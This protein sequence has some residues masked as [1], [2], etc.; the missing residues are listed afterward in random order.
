MRN[1]L[2]SI[3]CFSC[4]SAWSNDTAFLKVHFLYGSKPSKAYQDTE[5]KWFGGVLGGHV[6]IEGGQHK[7]LNFLPQ[8]SFHVFKKENNRHSTYA[9]HDTISFYGILGGEPNS[10]KKAVVYIPITLQQKQRFDS[11]AAAYLAETP[12]DYALVGMRCGSAAY[13]ILARL[14][15]LEQYGRKKTAKKIFYP[16][17]LRKRLLRKAAANHWTMTRQEGTYRRQWEKD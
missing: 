13:E 8:G 2:M 11:I 10:M 1:L 5:Q 17:K 14:G 16:K 7:I 4:I 15:I 3:A 12:Y 9:E 6:G